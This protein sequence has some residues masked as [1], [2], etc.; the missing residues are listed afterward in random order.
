MKIPNE[1]QL[2]QIAPNHSS[3]IDFKD[4]MKLYKDYTIEPY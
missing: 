2:Q 1:R 4:F 3:A